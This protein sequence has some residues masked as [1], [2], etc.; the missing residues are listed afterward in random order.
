MA[1]ASAPSGLPPPWGFMEFQKKV[2]FHTWA[3]WLNSPPELVLM[4]SSRDL[5]ALSVPSM[6]S[7]SLV[8]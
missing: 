3:A 8:T 2:W 7:F 1:L 4:I 5:S 6:S